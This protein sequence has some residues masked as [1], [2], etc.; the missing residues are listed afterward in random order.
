MREFKRQTV[1]AT[2]TITAP[3]RVNIEALERNI[4]RAIG[5]G[6]LDA[7]GEPVE[8]E[9]SLKLNIKNIYRNKKKE[10]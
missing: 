4:N 10:D 8:L 9:W 6:L 7:Y 1:A 3:A 2:L 5:S